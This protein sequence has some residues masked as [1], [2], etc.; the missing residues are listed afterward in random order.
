MAD[1]SL[2]KK[3]TG[4]KSS[5]LRTAAKKRS[6]S[7]GTSYQ[8]VDAREEQGSAPTPPVQYAQNLPPNMAPKGMAWIDSIATIP[9]LRRKREGGG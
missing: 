3:A 7:R 9:A 1:G 4:K 5:T 2:R 6:N 8:T